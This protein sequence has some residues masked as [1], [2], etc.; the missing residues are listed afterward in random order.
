MIIT[1][2]NNTSISTFGGGFRWKS[3]YTWCII[4]VKNKHFLRVFKKVKKNKKK[5]TEKQEILRKT[6]FRPNRFFYM[7]RKMFAIRWSVVDDRCSIIFKNKTKPSSYC[8]Q[9]KCCP[10]QLPP[11]APILNELMNDV[12]ILQ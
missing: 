11:L 5:M 8:P 9:N 1:S 2:R 6:S 7:V 10:G 12:L 3:K 4:E